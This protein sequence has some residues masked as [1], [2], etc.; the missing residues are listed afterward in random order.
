MI[1]NPSIFS[2][3][4]GSW[5]S[6]AQEILSLVQS[7]MRLRTPLDWGNHKESWSR[8]HE[9]LETDNPEWGLLAAWGILEN[10]AELVFGT[11]LRPMWSG[12]TDSI[13]KETISHIDMNSAEAKKLRS[14]TKKR[15]SV[16]HGSPTNV[17]WSDVDIVISAA[18][19]LHR[20]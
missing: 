9:A 1:A 16:A 19:R 10:Q 2:F 4:Q 7:G 15:N 8:L 18:Y 11:K 12:R 13:L 6:F 14:T 20:S 5:T 3:W 17:N